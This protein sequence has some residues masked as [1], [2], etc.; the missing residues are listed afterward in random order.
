MWR[1]CCLHSHART[2]PSGFDRAVNRPERN[3]S[4][5]TSGIC[6]CSL[7]AKN[8]NAFPGRHPR[9]GANALW[10]CL[11]AILVGLFG[12]TEDFFNQLESPFWLICDQI[13][14][15]WVSRNSPRHVSQLIQR[16]SVTWCNSRAFQCLSSRRQFAQLHQ[17]PDVQITSSS[18]TLA[19]SGSS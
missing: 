10:S 5:T 18:P 16:C 7:L 8:P 1:C 17:H 9:G 11:K 19:P 6:P 4:T 13:I 2:P 12:L 15:Q 3:K 14:R